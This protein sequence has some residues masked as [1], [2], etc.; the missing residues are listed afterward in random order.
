[1]RARTRFAIAAA[2]SLAGC[3]G[4][5]GPLTVGT[6]V[7]TGRDIDGAWFWQPRRLAYTRVAA[8]GM[9]SADD[10]WVHD[11]DEG[12][13]R[14]ALQDLEWSESSFW[15][16]FRIGNLLVTGD[17]SFM[18]AYDV[19]TRARGAFVAGQLPVL[20]RDGGAL[21]DW[22]LPSS[23]DESIH[24]GPLSA[25]RAID[26]FITRAADFI[27]TDLAVL[28]HRT[29]DPAGAQVIARV[30]S[31]DGSISTLAAGLPT[32]M[33]TTTSDLVVIGC[34]LPQLSCRYFQVL[35]CAA[36]T[37]ACPD[38]GEIPCA[39]AF[40]RDVADAPPAQLVPAV[41]DVNRGAMLRVDG[42]LP[43][44]GGGYLRSPDGLRVAWTDGSMMR[45]WD[46]CTRQ[47][48]GCQ[49][50]NLPV[51]IDRFAWRPDSGAVSAV[52]GRVE[53]LVLSVDDGTCT[54]P[55]T[56]A[57]SS[58][59]YSQDG[60]K[61]G[62]LDLPSSTQD[63]TL[64]IA[65]GRGQGAVATASGPIIDAVF[66]P[67]TRYLVVRRFHDNAVSIGVIDTAAAN[68]VERPI[69]SATAFTMA[70]GTRRLLAMTRWNSQ[71]RSGQIEL[72]DLAQGTSTVLAEP[73]TSLA[74]AGSVDDAT[75]IAY[76][77]RTRSPSAFDGLW[78]ATLPPVDAP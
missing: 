44:D 64:W 50:T 38:T 49:A 56:S 6:R 33:P 17:G 61:M 13:A 57:P 62:W 16:T 65:D 76:V 71:D 59:F 24:I 78:F 53:L 8:S 40:A 42:S 52:G 51:Q 30:S 45:V 32:W 19:E 46:A 47:T 11:L 73:V 36:D 68:P 41:Y 60:S 35:G 66:S 15:E 55:A 69:A 2:L 28:G 18:L 12:Q 26:G 7:E 31:A 39:I 25:A 29:Q 54:T 63:R 67:D 58:V 5:V 21:A 74:A 72:F 75:D 37:P 9:A 48:V 3:G 10:L 34:L 77:M 27:G 70:L 22:R 1:M 14:L 23:G 20:R 4:G 43:A